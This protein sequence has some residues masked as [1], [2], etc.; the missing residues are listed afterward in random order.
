MNQSNKSQ[1]GSLD[2]LQAAP[3]YH[4]TLF[5][6]DQVRVLDTNIAPGDTVPLHSHCWPRVMYVM[7]FYDFVRYDEQGNVMLD[8]RTLKN[9]PKVGEAIWSPP[10]A[11]HTLDNVGQSDLR[12]ITVELKS[13]N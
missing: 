2:A 11:P 7:S 8:S 13:G 6:N 12:V 3:D 1:P 9:K 4:T 10:L 5:E